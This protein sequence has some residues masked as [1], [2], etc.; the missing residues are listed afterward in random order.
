MHGGNLKFHKFFPNVTTKQ[1]SD[2][3]FY[4]AHIEFQI[5]S[6]SFSAQKYHIFKLIWNFGMAFK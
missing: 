1:Q 2:L 5:E 6:K 4:V 3:F